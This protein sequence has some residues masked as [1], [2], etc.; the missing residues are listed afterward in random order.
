MTD[1][2]KISTPHKPR[3]IHSQW[4]NYRNPS[5]CGFFGENFERLGHESFLQTLLMPEN[6]REMPLGGGDTPKNTQ[7]RDV[8]NPED[9]SECPK[10]P[11]YPQGHARFL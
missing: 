3:N 11:D 5:H 4:F 10:Q 1:K 2:V 8:V 6:I 7:D 9:D